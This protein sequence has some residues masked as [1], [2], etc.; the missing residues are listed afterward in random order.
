MAAEAEAEKLRQA[1][2]AIRAEREKLEAEKAIAAHAAVVAEREAV[3]DEAHNENLEFDHAKAIE[4]NE[5]RKAEAQAAQADFEAAH[6]AALVEHE[7][8]RK[9]QQIIAQDKQ[10]GRASCRERV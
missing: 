8:Y 2:E 1:Q 7:E 10:I 4:E 5:Q 3:W 6:A 9:R